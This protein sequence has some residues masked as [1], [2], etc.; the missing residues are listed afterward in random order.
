[1]LMFLMSILFIFSLVSVEF[2]SADT[3]VELFPGNESTLN[4]EI[5]KNIEML[6]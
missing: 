2:N 4:G 6:A 3:K 1:M 5:R